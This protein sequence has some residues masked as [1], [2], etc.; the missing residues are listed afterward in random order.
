LI[1]NAITYGKEG[2]KIKIHAG[3]K[4]DKVVVEI[5]DNG[6][7]ISKDD[8][9][10]IFERFYRADK[11]RNSEGKHSGLGLAMVK[12]ITDLHG[13][14]VEVKSTEGV[15]TTFTVTLPKKKA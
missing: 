1:D 9:P 7:G 12:W 11:S 2:G 13:G 4:K 14:K 5:A 8:L 10:H 6:I 15:G 3:D